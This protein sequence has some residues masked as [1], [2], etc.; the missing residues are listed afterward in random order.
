MASK[1]KNIE[2]RNPVALIW[3]KVFGLRFKIPVARGRTEK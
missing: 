3:I 2:G 1:I